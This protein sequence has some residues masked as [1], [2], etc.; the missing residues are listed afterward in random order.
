MGLDAGYR[1]LFI[2]YLK[3]YVKETNKTVLITSHIMSDLVDLIDDI[4]II[5]KDKEILQ[6]V[7]IL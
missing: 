7:E 3:D 6:I 1:R 4:A 5:Q 2:D